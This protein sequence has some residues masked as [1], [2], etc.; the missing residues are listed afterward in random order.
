MPIPLLTR[1]NKNADLINRNSIRVCDSKNSVDP[2]PANRSQPGQ[3]DPGEEALAAQPRKDIFLRD[4][5]MTMISASSCSEVVSVSNSAVLGEVFAVEVAYCDCGRG[6]NFISPLE[7][8]T[9]PEMDSVL[10]RLIGRLKTT[11]V[12]GAVG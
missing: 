2:K 1:P 5:G 7:V 11:A 9:C 10:D 6:D 4:L 3:A 8:N 12:I